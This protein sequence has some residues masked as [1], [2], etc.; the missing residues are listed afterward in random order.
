MFKYMETIILQ[1]IHETMS[2]GQ[3]MNTSNMTA[4]LKQRQSV[5]AFS[6]KPV[7]ESLLR[8]VVEMAGLSPSGGNVQP[9]RVVV[10]TGAALQ[11][12]CQQIEQDLSAG[13]EGD[14][15]EFPVYPESMQEPYRSRR[16]ESGE[17]LYK[18]LQIPRE[19]KVARITQ[20]MKNF[21]FFDAPVG[22]LLFMDRAM[23]E[24]QCMDMGIYLQS[25][26]LLA[27]ERGLATCPQVSWSMWPKTVRKALKMDESFQLMVGVSLGYADE[28]QPLNKLNQQR[29]DIAD[30]L[31]YRHE[32][33]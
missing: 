28:S 10:L 29:A 11:Q 6:D 27:E 31:D 26:L 30:W 17:K 19:D 15:P 3:N 9:W 1:S 21:R 7:P 32:L 16:F 24:P 5:R 4:L 33:D 8:E 25:L 12:F 22:I 18:A 23:A 2:Q 20:V 13:A 14:A